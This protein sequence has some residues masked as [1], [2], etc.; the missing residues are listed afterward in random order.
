MLRGENV[1]VLV[2]YDLFGVNVNGLIGVYI[3]T[4]ESTKKLLVHFPINGEWG[5]LKENQIERVKPGSV[6]RENKKFIA[7]IKP[8]ETTF[9]TK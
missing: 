8:L 5:E 2:D 3:K 6:T 9:P 4:D 1:K 7:K